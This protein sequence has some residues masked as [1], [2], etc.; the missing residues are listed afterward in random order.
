MFRSPVG[1]LFLLSA[2]AACN[3]TGNETAPDAG[4]A[5]AGFTVG[6]KDRLLLQGTVVTPWEAFDGQV[7]VE[8]SRITCVAPGSACEE[9]PGAPGA[10][11]IDTGGVIAPGLVDTHN[12]ILFDV[13]DGDDWTPS[14]TYRNHNEWTSEPGYQ[15]MLEVKHCLSDDS[16]GKPGWCAQTPYGTATGS[17]RCEM[18][19]FG[20]LKGLIAGT[21]SIV[22][23]AGTSG[24]CFGSLARSIDTGANGLGSD[25][26][27]TS[28]LFPPSAATA[29]SVCGAFADGGVNAFL[30]HCG[31]GT[32]VAALN[33][34]ATLGALGAGCLKAPQTTLT[35][36]TAFGSNELSDMASHGVRLTWSP[37]SNASLYGD[38]ANIPGARAAGVQVALGPDWSMGGSQNLPEE[39]RFAQ[40]WDTSH[41][42][43]SLTPQDLVV[44]ATAN[45]AAVVG[46]SQQL[47]QLAV[48]FLADLFVV[49]GDRQNPNQAIVEATPR[50]VALVLVG[51]VVQYGDELWR[52]AAASPDD[53]EALDVC[54][55]PK[56]LCMAVP[57]G[58][59]KLS[60]TWTDVSTALGN[61]MDVVDTA[62]DAG[63]GRHY[64]PLPPLVTCGY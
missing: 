57:D 7:L 58:G 52:D 51:G 31:E 37:R 4:S 41:W 15:A 25:R 36:G 62:R 42:N 33:E 63:D 32:D 49:R 1:C 48:G 9:A 21:T 60:Q 35:H 13:F 12:H 19:K 34:Y 26:V 5:D 3:P 18:D 46:Q 50:T 59:A 24:A 53:C 27:R 55:S 11:R 17:L 61:A 28:A 54:G 14:R 10:T 20:E 6:A 8:G 29:T 45:G 39:L 22:G 30:V 40:A 56:V 47:G 38:T 16:Q 43:G 44:M 23:L 64:A 2:F